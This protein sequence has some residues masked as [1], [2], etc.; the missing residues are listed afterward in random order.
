M[1]GR[2]TLKFWHG[3]VLKKD[4]H[5][6]MRYEGGMGKSCSADPDE[7]CWWDLRDLACSC[8]PYE[9]EMIEGLYY[10][11]PGLSLDEGLRKVYDDDEV[12]KMGELVVETRCIQLYVIHGDKNV[13]KKDVVGTQISQTK[14]PA[15]AQVPIE[16]SPKKNNN[17]PK[18]LTPKRPNKAS[19]KPCRTSPR[20][21]QLVDP[22]LLE[23]PATLIVGDSVKS[24]QLHPQ[25]R[26][27]RCS[28]NPSQISLET[29]PLS[30][31]TGPS[32]AA[33]E[34]PIVPESF[35]LFERQ[36]V[37]ETYQWED[38][39]PDSPIPLKEL[40]GDDAWSDDDSDGDPEYEPDSDSLKGGGEVADDA[41]DASDFDDLSDGLEEIEE[42]D[43]VEVVDDEGVET[44]DDELQTARER[45][46]GFNTKVREIALKLQQDAVEGRLGQ[47]Q[48]RSGGQPS[49]EEPATEYH[50]EYEDSDEEIDTPPESGD[51]E[52][53][54]QRRTK[55]SLLVGNDTDFKVFKWRVGQR[56][57][58]RDEF[59]SAVAKYGILQG[60]NL[61]F[62]ISNKNRQQRIGVRCVE[63]CSFKLYSSWD[64]RKASFVVKTVVDEHTCTRN[65]DRNR[66]LKSTWLAQQLLEVF[67]ARP[68]WPANEI[69]QTVR[70]GYRA[71]ITGIAS[72]FPNAEHRHCARHIFALWHKSFR[73]DEMKLMFWKIVKAYNL[74]DYDDALQQLSEV[75]NAAA[76][77][78]RSYNPNLFCRA[79]MG[80][81]CK[82]DVVT[83][84]MAET[85]NG[86]IINARTK[87]VIHMMEEIRANLM[88][89][90]VKKREEM[91]KHNSAICPRIHVK[92]EKEKEEASKCD[93]LPSTATLFQVNHYLDSMTVNLEEKTCTCRK[94]DLTGIPCCHAIAA[95]YF[96]H[97]EAEEYVH[98][99]YKKETYLKA[100]SGSIPPVEGERHW[101][102]V[103]LQLDPPPIKIGPG[104]P[105][106]NRRKDP[107][108]DP[109][110]PGK[111]SKHGMEMTCSVCNN[112]GHNKR[113]C[114]NKD[115]AE[116]TQP[117]PKRP[118]GRPR[119]QPT[120]GNQQHPP[121]IS[122]HPH[123]H[124]I[125]A[126]PTLLGRGGELLGV[127]EGAEVEAQAR[128]LE[129]QPGEGVQ[130]QGGVVEEL[131]Q[132]R[133]RGGATSGGRG[134]RGR[135]R[136][137]SSLPQGF[138]VLI[139]ADG[140]TMTNVPGSSRG[141][142]VVTDH[143]IVTSQTSQAS[144]AFTS[145]K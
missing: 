81:S 119:L 91:D 82:A 137:T 78:F 108:E 107:F 25:N 71:I 49:V 127:E 21:A 92:L 122:T 41:S 142:R 40:L 39:R 111:L 101:P 26:S 11:I 43:D 73:G 83:N 55:R 16:V 105:R 120:S 90:L 4:N 138:G 75:S 112:K 128:E 76:I 89:R 131:H 20:N 35:P 124:A 118:R 64:S 1:A 33:T 102:K 38:E 77:A 121:T 57:P 62:V 19:L 116:P 22:T 68:H 48:I 114:P 58:S 5:G 144:T 32:K 103:G 140:S 79:F 132:G 13:A 60:R 84:N 88:Q 139:G 36:I 51:D 125:T 69:I 45:V 7:L 97:R 133:G 42:G 94:W 104:R 67:K 95:I 30:Y 63:G 134:R 52:T 93:V 135:G 56:F 15:P 17:R 53:I 80:T 141:P 14:D 6:H 3:G 10:L 12:R 72:V 23:S 28:A 130:L 27:E 145:L 113:R 109:K 100:Y 70:L 54:A 110:R 29:T 47:Q 117:Q 24:L 136:A 129:Q 99:Y 65:M 18:K 74:A 46:K 98:D 9:K 50:S 2:V 66:Q 143:T 115:R 96:C 106:K 87:H 123:H 61:T 85:F 59:K 34:P 8:G 31:T 86:Y 126:E 37:P 44:S